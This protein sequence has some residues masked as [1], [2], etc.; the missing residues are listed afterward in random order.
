ML[1]IMTSSFLSPHSSLFIIMRQ[2]DLC[3][4]RLSVSEVHRFSFFLANHVLLLLRLTGCFS[5]CSKPSVFTL[6]SSLNCST[7]FDAD[8]PT[9]WSVFLIWPDLFGVFL[10]RGKKVS[11]NVSCGVQDQCIFSNSDLFFFCFYSVMMAGI[12]L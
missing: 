9:S 1:H 11:T 10:H 12:A 2:V 8:P 4:I 6:K 7:H 5:S 3:L